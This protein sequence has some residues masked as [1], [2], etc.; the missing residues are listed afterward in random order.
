M[1]SK[2]SSLETDIADY[3]DLLEAFAGAG[4]T[5]QFLHSQQMDLWTIQ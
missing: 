1:C 2:R 4:S 3:G 5:A